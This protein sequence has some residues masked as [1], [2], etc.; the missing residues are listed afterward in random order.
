MKR[1]VSRAGFGKVR[2]NAI[3]RLDHEMHVN[4]RGNTVLAQRRAHEGSDRKVRHVVIVHHIKVHDICTRSEHGIDFLA[5]AREVGRENRRSNPQRL[6][7][8]R[9]PEQVG[10]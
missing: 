10:T 5:Q 1:N 4:R 2:N 9:P 7:V 8:V 3:D 6:H